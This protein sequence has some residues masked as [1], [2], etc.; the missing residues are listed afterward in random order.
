MNTSPFVLVAYAHDGLRLALSMVETLE[1]IADVQLLSY[2][3]SGK[4]LTRE[5]DAALCIVTDDESI[6]QAHE[7]QAGIEGVP[8]FV[9]DNSGG[10]KIH[11]NGFAGKVSSA[12][13][14]VLKTV[15]QLLAA[16]AKK[17]QQLAPRK[18]AARSPRRLTSPFDQTLARTTGVGQTPRAIL[19]AATR[20]LAWDL[21]AERIDAF[22]HVSETGTYQMVHAEP[23]MAQVR[24]GTPS[25]EIVRL[26]KKRFYPATLAEM[27][28][29]AF[30]SLHHY[31]TGRKMNVLV[32]LVQ[33]SHLLGWLTLNLDA[34]R[35]TDD[36]L[37]DLQ[38]AAH[39]LTISVAEAYRREQACQDAGM[40][41]DAFTALRSGILIIDEEGQITALS[42]ETVLLG[43]TPL[44]GESFKSVHNSRVREVVSHAL[45]GDFIEKSWVDFDSQATISCRSTPL[46][47]GKIV[48]FW[49][50]AQSAHPAGE[51]PNRLPG[52]DLKEVLESLPVPVVLDAAGA[53]TPAAS[54]LP[55]GRISDWDG[56]AIRACAQQAEAR[57]A[58]SLRL[59]WGKSRSPVNAV[60][61]YETASGEANSDFSD[62]INRAVRFSVVTA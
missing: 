23:E 57:K 21:R 27:E 56:Q 46:G 30:R 22:L 14:Q 59:R 42:G 35:C 2:E 36:F 29:R 50:P 25:S 13:E 55:R 9:V 41:N 16:N 19:M 11:A 4:H 58:K 34:A 39:L 44:K 15:R 8:T 7:F 48:L 40:L 47:D 49:G 43:G 61:F 5:P 20:Q 51:Q 12:P 31:L 45:R 26:I 38:V 62:D 17:N 33:E 32:P 54:I 24:N 60:L 1:P 10:R 52:F 53:A 6:E 28:S 18:E 37:D 3:Q